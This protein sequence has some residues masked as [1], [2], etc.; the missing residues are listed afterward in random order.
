MRPIEEDPATVFH[1]GGCGGYQDTGRT[2]LLMDDEESILEAFGK[3]LSL[4][5][6]NV[7]TARDGNEALS[8]YR[9]ALD[10]HKPIDI[11]ILDLTVPGG[12]GGIDT[13]KKLRE[14][15]PGVCALISSGMPQGYGD[16]YGSFGFAGAI[17]KPY[18]WEELIIAINE[19][20]SRK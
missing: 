1:S 7:L 13:M 8:L 12:M 9:H 10:T 3:L 15:D 17:P 5:G 6:F 16:G 18:R 19:A 14:I 11:V 20:I 2:V 4:K